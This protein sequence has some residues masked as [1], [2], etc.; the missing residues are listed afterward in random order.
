MLNDRLE[1]AV[2]TLDR[3]HVAVEIAFRHHDDQGDWLLWLMIQ[4]D[5]GA[6]AADSP[7]PIDR[8]HADF[9]HRCRETPWL[10]A[11]PQV[12][13]LPAPVRAAILD[14]ALRGQAPATA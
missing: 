6:S 8:D 4:G 3:E 11:E 10:E 9:A 1:E 2:E 13:L 12:L 5:H 7:F 14:W